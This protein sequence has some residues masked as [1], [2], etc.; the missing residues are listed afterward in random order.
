[1]SFCNSL[2]KQIQSKTGLTEWALALRVVEANS[3]LLRKQKGGDA[4]RFCGALLRG[5]SR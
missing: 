4:F 5:E 1:M 3:G 2:G